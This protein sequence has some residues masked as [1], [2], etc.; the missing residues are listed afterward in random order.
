M[1]PCIHVHNM[2]MM[3]VREWMSKQGDEWKS[4]KQAIMSNRYITSVNYFMFL[5]HFIQFQKMS[6][7][8]KRFKFSFYLLILF[9]ICT[10]SNNSWAWFNTMYKVTCFTGP[11]IREEKPQGFSFFIHFNVCLQLIFRMFYWFFC[12]TFSIIVGNLPEISIQTLYTAG[13]FLHSRQ[14]WN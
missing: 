3:T 1:T 14:L 2:N 12:R 13:R 5:S 11:Y 4:I 10:T 6:T 9:F 8:W 7:S